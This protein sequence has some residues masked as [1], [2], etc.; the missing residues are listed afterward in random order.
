MSQPSVQLK[1]LIKYKQINLCV[2]AAAAAA[3]AIV[4]DAA[5]VVVG[6]ILLLILSIPLTLSHPTKCAWFYCSCA[7]SISSI[8]HSHRAYCRTK[9]IDLLLWAKNSAI[10]FRT[11]RYTNKILFVSAVPMCV[12]CGRWEYGAACETQSVCIIYI[13]LML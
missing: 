6:K 3:A 11:Q 12:P 8:A 9:W 2:V 5:S 7:S 10:L 4:A 1:F 13:T